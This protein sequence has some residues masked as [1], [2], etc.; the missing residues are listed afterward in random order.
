MNKSDSIKELSIALNKAQA[1]M[2]AAL[3]D[4][5]NPFFKAAYADFTSVW[6]TARTP[7]TDNGLSIIQA[8]DIDE[9]GNNI[10]ETMLCH[11]SGEF[12]SGRYNMGHDANPQKMGSAMTYARRYTLSAILCM[13][14]EE[15]DDG[16]K[17]STTTTKTAPKTEA[18]KE[19]SE[20]PKKLT[21]AEQIEKMKTAENAFELKARWTKYE[22]D[23]KALSAI[24]Q[25]KVT[26]AKDARK[27]ELSKKPVKKQLCADC[28]LMPTCERE[29]PQGD[30]VC[31][32][33]IPKEK[34]EK[35]EL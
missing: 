23:R 22:P 27:V 29:V 16:N 1:T 32:D 2:K 12:V 9:H 6:E 7:L 31:M 26:I 18:K 30:D 4:S 25:K 21:L 3:K 8:T 11:V 15:D 14:T 33:M 24:D 13:A 5:D 35:G 19:A 17:A 20:A 34:T 10:L 28:Q